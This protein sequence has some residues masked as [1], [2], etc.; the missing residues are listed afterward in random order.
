MK[1]PD[2]IQ[3]FLNA[4]QNAWSRQDVEAIIAFFSKEFEFEDIPIGL[5]ATNASEMRE[6]LNTTF[7][8]VPNFTMNI[9]EH[10]ISKDIVT[11]K[12]Y[13]SG[14]MTTQV[15]GLDLKDK[16]YEVV[17]TSIIG[18]SSDGQITSVSDN[19]N[20]AVFFQ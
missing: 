9:F 10:H 2:Q 7:E 18:L 11:T 5:H 17:T 3:N 6:V 1:D 13:Q 8:S 15:N 12:W 4:W 19:W 14:N 16:P 20:A